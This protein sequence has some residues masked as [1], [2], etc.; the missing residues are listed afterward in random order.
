M[1]YVT[2]LCHSAGSFR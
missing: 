1:K 2:N